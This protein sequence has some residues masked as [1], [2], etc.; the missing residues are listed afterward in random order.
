MYCFS[1]SVSRPKGT[2][3][4]RLCFV[5]FAGMLFANLVYT[6]V[7]TSG[8]IE[9]YPGG[10]SIVVLNG[11]YKNIDNGILSYSPA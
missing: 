4:G 3:F 1:Y 2:L 7:Y 6:L 9:N 5:A 8:S 10:A 11:Y